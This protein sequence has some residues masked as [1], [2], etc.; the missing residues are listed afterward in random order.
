MRWSSAP[1]GGGAISRCGRAGADV[2]VLRRDGWTVE[3]SAPVDRYAGLYRGGAG[4]T[5]ALERPAVVLPGRADLG[6]TPSRHLLFRPSRVP[7]LA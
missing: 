2:I 1:G 7:A 4:A 5:V 3:S 6:G